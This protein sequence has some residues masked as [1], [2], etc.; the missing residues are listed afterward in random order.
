[1]AN[2]GFVLGKKTQSDE[3]LDIELLNYQLSN[4]WHKH[5]AQGFTKSRS[6]HH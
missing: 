6:V 1:M 2:H 3:L 5:L 4:S